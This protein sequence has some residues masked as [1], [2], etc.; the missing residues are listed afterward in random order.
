M[1][2]NVALPYLVPAAG[3]FEAPEW[4]IA[5]P[6][7]S[8]QLVD[9]VKGW[10]YSTNLSLSV[11]IESNLEAA[12]S[13]CGLGAGPS[14]GGFIV[15]RSSSTALRGTSDVVV[16]KTGR[17]QVGLDLI[18]IEIGGQLEIEARVVFLAGYAVS[19]L[20]PTRRGALL[21][22]EKRTTRLEGTADRFPIELRD[23]KKAGLRGADGAWVLHWD[24]KDPEWSASAAVRL[25]LNS[26]HPMADR[27]AGELPDSDGM[28]VLRYDLTR[29]LIDEALDNDDLSDREWP[30]GSLGAALLERVKSVFPGLSLEDCRAMRRDRRDDYESAIQQTTG[31]LKGK[32]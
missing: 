12:V 31:M 5:S 18:G 7:Y 27:L 9:E 8:G 30:A 25:W 24:S 21:W 16:L 10:D 20:A 28:S 22:S 19:E 26:R 32:D 11:C 1:K 14:L 17:N 6:S 4:L 23:F 3:R 15:W 29:Q 13:D 2:A